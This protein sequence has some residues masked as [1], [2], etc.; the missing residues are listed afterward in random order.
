MK[1]LKLI[2]VAAFSATALFSACVSEGE[3][4][5]V[6]YAPDMYVSK[7]Y[8]P[9]SQVADQ[10]RS[11][12]FQGETYLINKDGKT[13]R[14][15]VE[16]TIARGKMDFIFNYAPGDVDEKERAG[17]ELS[18]PVP[19]TQENLEAG[20]RHYNINCS[21][22]HGD[23]GL[24]D[25]L[26]GQKYPKG[27]VPSYKTDRIHNLKDGSLYYVITHGWNVMGSYGKMINPTERWQVV[28][29]INYLEQ[30]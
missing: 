15:P 6:E 17:R 3:D 18:N 26:V 12:T 11:I 8:E 29:Y 4:P 23:K 30:N 25:G 10:E 16:G 27:L 5:G 20:R 7:G 22:C 2:Y 24:G 13:M 19:L 28:H 9:Y 14:E 1:S 21:P